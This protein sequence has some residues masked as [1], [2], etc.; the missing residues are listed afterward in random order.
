MTDAAGT[1]V[2]TGVS[3]GLGRALLEPLISAGHIIAG[4][5]RRAE[6]IQQLR[7]TFGSP[8]CFETVDVAQ[9]SEVRSWS[10]FILESL[11]PPD[12][13]INNAALINANAPLWEVPTDEFS[14]L[15]D[16][17]IK[18]IFHVMKAFLPAMIA[19]QRGV[20]VNLSSGWGRSASADVAPYCATKWAVEG[21]T[22]SLAQE[23]PDGM[24]AVPLNP[25]IIDTEMLQ[26]CFGSDAGAYPSPDQWARRAVPFLLSL[27]QEDN[28]RPL[29]M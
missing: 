5:A 27:S 4:C 2:I 15:I 16:V 24:A 14:Q 21:L 20:I 12:L 22:Q 11:G 3:R 19:R 26:S 10:E 7:S 8:H 13:L 18:G 6:P 29:T 17:N 1:I 28:G 9:E 25:G 23:L